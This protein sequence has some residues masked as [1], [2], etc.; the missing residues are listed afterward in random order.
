MARWLTAAALF[1][2]LFP[3]SLTLSV[4]AQ[5]GRSSATCV[6]SGQVTSS[7]TPLPGV[8]I[9]V[10]SGEGAT[11]VTSSGTDGRFDL[12]VAGATGT[13]TAELTGFTRI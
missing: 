1:V 10:R 3:L 2:V 11:K 9:T 8:A 5:E 13:V 4:E 6:V 7:G 12:A